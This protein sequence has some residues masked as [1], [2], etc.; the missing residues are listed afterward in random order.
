MTKTQNSYTD[1]EVEYPDMLVLL[2]LLGAPDPVFY[3]YMSATERWYVRL[4][5]AEQQLAS[6]NQLK[7]YSRDKAEQKYFRLASSN[8]YIEDDHIPFMRRNV[9]VLHVIP[10]PFPRVW[11][12][13]A[14]DHSALD[15]NTIENLNKIMRVFVA[16]YL[17][18]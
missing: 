4:A 11:H 7:G 8:A 18:L 16:E 15:Y 17:H 3:S 14:D 2:D 10:T 1:Y 12:T 6:L 9:D 13:A 5:D